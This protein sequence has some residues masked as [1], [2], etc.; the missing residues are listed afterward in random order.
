[1]QQRTWGCLVL[2]AAWLALAAGQE[3]NR[4]QPCSNRDSRC[5]TWAGSTQCH[6]NPHFMLDTCPAA[7]KARIRP[8]H[9]LLACVQPA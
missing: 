4:E 2:A 5:D 8:V 7:C 9:S 3:A 6:E 1:M